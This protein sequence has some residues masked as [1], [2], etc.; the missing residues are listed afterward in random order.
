MKGR[1]QKLDVHMPEQPEEERPLG[2]GEDGPPTVNGLAGDPYADDVSFGLRRRRAP[3]LLLAGIL[4]VA[5]A[6][7]LIVAVL[8]AQ[9]ILSAPPSPI[10]LRPVVL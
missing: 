3:R 6:V 4:L 2:T 1:D 8:F 7:L 10:A 9:A 5:A